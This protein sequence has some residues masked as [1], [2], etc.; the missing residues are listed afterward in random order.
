MSQ[1]INLRDG[2]IAVVI[3]NNASVIMNVNTAFEAIA[4]LFAGVTCTEEV[5]DTSKA[6]PVIPKNTPL[7]PSM[8]KPV[9]P[10]DPFANVPEVKSGTVGGSEKVPVLVFE[11]NRGRAEKF[12]DLRE[13]VGKCVKR[14]DSMAEVDRY[15]GL[16]SG[17]TSSVVNTWL[18]YNHCCGAMNPTVGC[19]KNYRFSSKFGGKKLRWNFFPYWNS[20]DFNHDRAVAFRADAIPPFI[21][22]RYAR[23]GK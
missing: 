15:Y 10:V 7:T 11:F 6:E 13:G 4:K 3:G 8:P 18:P 16:S 20:A 5:K 17:T 23:K 14:F 21:L 12:N 19:Q 9:K 1:N 2:E 22:D